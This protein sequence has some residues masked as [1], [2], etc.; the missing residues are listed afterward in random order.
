[1]VH[2]L[3]I[4]K[5]QS[6]QTQIIMFLASYFIIRQFPLTTHKIGSAERKM[7]VGR[8]SEGENK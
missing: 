3:S 8:G 5:N 4:L 7:A 1:M 6:I 2:K